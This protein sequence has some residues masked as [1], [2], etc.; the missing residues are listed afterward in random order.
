MF[1]AYPTTPPGLPDRLG[2]VLDGLRRVLAAHAAKDR[3]LAALVLILWSRLGRLQAR[4]AAIVARQQAGTLRKP[5]KASQRRT[6]PSSR[7]P[8]PRPP[9]PRLPPPCDVLPRRRGWLIRRVQECVAHGNHLQLLLEDPD[10]R[11]LLEAAPQLRP[12]FRPLWR[13]LRFD[14]LP[15]ALRSPEPPSRRRKPAHRRR[16]RRPAGRPPAPRSKAW[17]AEQTKVGPRRT[18]AVRSPLKRGA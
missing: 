4:V 12:L 7:P 15:E 1:V 2:L 6:P 14:P 16:K 8:S 17:A 18:P 9:S 13:M 10:T 5:A 3:A 11:A